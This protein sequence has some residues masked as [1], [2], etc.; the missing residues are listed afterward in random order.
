VRRSS[1]QLG[2]LLTTFLVAGLFFCLGD[3]ARAGYVAVQVKKT[4]T[5]SSLVQLDTSDLSS[6][7]LSVPST[8]MAPAAPS[9]EKDQGDKVRELPTAPTP[10]ANSTP[11]GA[12]APSSG[13]SPS[14]AGFAGTLLALPVSQDVPQPAMVG[15]LV[16]ER[17]F[18]QPDPVASGLFHPPR[19]TN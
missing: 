19:D 3:T 12:G 18:Y 4:P 8:G 2:I 9:D 17:L 14:G 11:P 5:S 16:G 15:W 1:R 7:T 13:P 6:D 10:V